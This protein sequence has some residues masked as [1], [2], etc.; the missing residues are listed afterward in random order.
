[1]RS[2]KDES[3]KFRKSSESYCEAALEILQEIAGADA[4]LHMWFNIELD[5]RSSS[6]IEMKR[7]W[8]QQRALLLRTG[9]PRT[10]FKKIF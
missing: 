8:R 10:V 3:T 1:M 4:N 7:R 9:K 2:N 5:F 6:L